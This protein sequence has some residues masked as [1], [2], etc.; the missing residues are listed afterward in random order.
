M[1][2][3][4]CKLGCVEKWLVEDEISWVNCYDLLLFSV[5]YRCEEIC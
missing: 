2:L 1:E 4:N 3:E 5:N